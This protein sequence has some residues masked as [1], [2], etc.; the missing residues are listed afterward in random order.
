MRYLGATTRHERHDFALRPST[1]MSALQKRTIGTVPTGW[2]RVVET[3]H[4]GGW[5]YELDSE[6]CDESRHHSN[7][8]A[9]FAM[10]L[11]GE[12]RLNP[13]TGTRTEAATTSPSW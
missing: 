4:L 13:L 7:T 5:A 3:T 6:S 1:S 2:C 11:P 10:G 12:H 9:D 8:L